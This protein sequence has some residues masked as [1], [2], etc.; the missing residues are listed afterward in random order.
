[1]AFQYIRQDEIDRFTRTFAP[2]LEAVME[3][4]ELSRGFLEEVVPQL[5]GEPPTVIWM[6]GAAC[7]REFEEIQMLCGTGFGT[8]ATKLLRAFY[9]RVVTLAITR[10][11]LINQVGSGTLGLSHGQTT[12]GDRLR[13]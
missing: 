11:P 10:K 1:M 7:L 9:E 4:T 13:A 12:K 2:V 3:S 5:Q 8:G 6:L